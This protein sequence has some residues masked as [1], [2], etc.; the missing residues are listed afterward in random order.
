MTKMPKSS[1]KW[2]SESAE[3]TAPPSAEALWGQALALLARREH[4]RMELAQKLAASGADEAQLAGVF[5]RLNVSQLQ[6]DERFCEVFVRSRLL[7]GQGPLSIGQELKL[8]GVAS[9]L[10]QAYV[11]ESDIDWLA[12]AQQVRQRRFGD[13]LPA[14]KREQAR[15]LRFLLYRGFAAGLAAKALRYRDDD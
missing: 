10:I 8:R 3:P 5:E 15:Q 7:K 11:Q 2:T 13:E 14:D 4:S 12:Q 1:T 6:S 9:E